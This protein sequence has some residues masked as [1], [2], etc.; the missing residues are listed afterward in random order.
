MQLVCLHL[1][2][3]CMGK[4]AVSVRKAAK[5]KINISALFLILDL[6]NNKKNENVIEMV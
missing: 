4:L 1:L 3:I 5:G 2:L 6:K